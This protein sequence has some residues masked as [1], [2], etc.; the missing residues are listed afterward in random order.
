MKT[1]LN[2]IATIAAFLM[3]SSFT[4]KDPL[5]IVGTYGITGSDPSQIKLVLEADHTF[6]YQD[7]SRLNR[8]IYTQGTWAMKGQK[9]VL[10]GIDSKNKFHNVWTFESQGLVAKSRRGLSFYRLC[11]LE[12]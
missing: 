10:T 6:V 5:H 7:L 9:V 2:L 1:N 8:K 12:E 3:L 11:R 4:G